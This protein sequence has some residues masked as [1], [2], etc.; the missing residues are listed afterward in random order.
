MPLS[1]DEL[2]TALHFAGHFHR[3][4]VWA[5]VP[6]DLDRCAFLFDRLSE[7]DDGYFEVTHAGGIGGA[8]ATPWFSPVRTAHELFWYSH[9]PG[10]GKAMRDRFEGWAKSKGA[11]IIQ[12]SAMANDREG[13][14]RRMMSR[15]GYDAFE[16]SFRKAL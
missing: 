13:A 11:E 10:E 5:H 9:D 7:S 3:K 4:S 8:I 16:V 1:A 12:F 6:L 14:L 15:A 2:E